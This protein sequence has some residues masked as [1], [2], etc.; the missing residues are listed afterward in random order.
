MGMTYAV[1]GCHGHGT[2]IL[3]TE[4]SPVRV[5]SALMMVGDQRADREV[6]R[7]S[8][9]CKETCGSAMGWV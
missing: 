9:T 1:V 5:A 2:L 8:R 6:W 3:R 4:A 7:K